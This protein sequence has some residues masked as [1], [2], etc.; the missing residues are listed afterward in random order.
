MAKK[1][2]EKDNMASALAANEYKVIIIGGLGVGKTSLLLRFVHDT[3]E[4][5]VSRFVAEEKKTVSVDGHEVVL[6]IWD[7]AGIEGIGHARC[8]PSSI[9]CQLFMLKGKIQL[10]CETTPVESGVALKSKVGWGSSEILLTAMREKL[11]AWGGGG[12]ACCCCCS[13]SLL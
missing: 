12:R 4:D 3:F 9:A 6:D 11:E 8:P 7:T 5:R 13:F 2:T 10:V 1:S